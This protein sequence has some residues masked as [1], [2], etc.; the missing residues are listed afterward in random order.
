[1]GFQQQVVPWWLW[2]FRLFLK[3]RPCWKF[4]RLPWGLTQRQ[5][6]LPQQWMFGPGLLFH[7]LAEKLQWRRKGLPRWALMADGQLQ[8]GRLQAW[9]LGLMP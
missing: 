4:E 7:P 6:L 5:L 3:G 8:W 2:R 1:M 9:M